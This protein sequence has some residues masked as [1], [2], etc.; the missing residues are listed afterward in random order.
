MDELERL[1]RVYRARASSSANSRLDVLMDIGLVRDVRVVPFLLDVLS[2]RDEKEEVRIYVMK[3]LRPAGG[4]V[5]PAHESEAAQAIGDVLNDPGTVEL[6][7]QAA[8]MLGDFTRNAGVLAKLGAISLAEVESID[9]RYA[10][11]TSV[12]RAGPKPESVAVLRQIARDDTL[13]DAARSVLSAWH[14]E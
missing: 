9:L 2:D 10:A 4:L 13:G 8:L 7:I 6:R 3:L 11:F 1:M 14:V 12:E 5:T